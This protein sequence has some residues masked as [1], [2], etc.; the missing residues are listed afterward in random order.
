MTNLITEL[1][2]EPD[3]GRVMVILRERVNKLT[4]DPWKRYGLLD[5]FVAE[6]GRLDETQSEGVILSIAEISDSFEGDVFGISDWGRAR[7][8]LFAAAKRFEGGPKLQE[9]LTEAIQR[10][11]S[12]AFAADILGFSTSARQQNNIIS[13]WQRVNESA[14]KSA[15]SERMRKRYFAAS[16]REFSYRRDDLR[17][18]FIWVNASDQDKQQEIT[19]FRE[20]FRRHPVELGKFLGWALPRETL[21]YQGDPLLTPDKLFPLDELFELVRERTEE[22]WRDQDRES[23]QWFLELMQQRKNRAP[24]QESP[25]DEPSAAAEIEG[26]DVKHSAGGDQALEDPDDP[27]GSEQT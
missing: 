4:S 5:T 1:N 24:E 23:V 7:A 22:V 6:A 8:L 11:S 9:V 3:V 17:P 25:P 26:I 21:I 16:E 19:F 27:V 20:R 15:F 12:N 13:N 18:F 2:A 10:C 14:L